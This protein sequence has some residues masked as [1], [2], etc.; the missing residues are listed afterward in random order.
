[1]SDVVKPASLL[2]ACYE[3]ID[4][5]VSS[6]INVLRIILIGLIILGHGGK[7]LTVIV[8]KMGTVMSFVFS[9]INTNV[10]YATVPLFFAIS[11]F[12]FLRKF[13]L[14]RASYLNMLHKKFT[15]LFIPF[16]LFNA[17][18]MLWFYFVGSIDMFGSWT[19]VKEAGIIN[20]LLGVGTIPVNYPTWFL[21]DL[22]IIF[23]V[24][25]VFSLLYREMPMTGLVALFAFWIGQDDGGAYSLYGHA[26]SFYAGG[27]LARKNANLR[28]TAGFDALVIPGFAL[29][30]LFFIFKDH[31]ALDPSLVGRLF[32][33][34]SWLGVVFFWCV[35]RYEFLKKSKLLQKMAAYS[36][37][38]FLC[39][40]PLVSI[41][42]THVIVFWR[43][44]SDLEQL[45]FYFGSALVTIFLLYGLGLA[46]SKYTP[47]VYGFCVG[48][49]SGRRPLA[50][51]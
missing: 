33:C 45:V 51:G 47:R 20:K 34:Y 36:F 13:E 28:D 32:K 18:W 49:H 8:P 42:Q 16:V 6:R 4:P 2:P 25:P 24:C 12:L 31:F 50:R 39:H 27:L 37:F 41:M 48:S 7:A 19:S 1:L 44:Q 11:G 3:P 14:T 40:E 29:A 10:D 15:G 9:M 43:P 22:L 26:F 46:L 38:I 35:S 21:R 17:I 30:T 5:D 23:L